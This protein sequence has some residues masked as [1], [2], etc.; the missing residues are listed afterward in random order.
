[1]GFT[2]VPDDAGRSRIVLTSEPDYIVPL[3]IAPSCLEDELRIGAWLIVCM[4]VWN[5]HD[6]RA[7]HQALEVVKR[8]NGVVR[9]G[10]RP[11]DYVQENAVWIPDLREQSDQIEFRVVEQAHSKEIRIK[12]LPN[13]NPVWVVISEGKIIDIR[14]GLLQDSEIEELID[15][16]LVSHKT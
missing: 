8:R 16:L 2:F 11:F 1:M 5:F 9:L 13:A 15:K 14:Y 3:R 7:G 6:V 12:G 10:L 4:S